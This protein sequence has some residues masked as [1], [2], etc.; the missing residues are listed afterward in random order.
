MKCFVVVDA[1]S[2]EVISASLETGR[3]EQHEPGL[4]RP[5][6]RVGEPGP[7]ARPVAAD[8]QRVLE[9]DVDETLLTG[10]VDDSMSRLRESVRRHLPRSG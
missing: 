6:D 1:A 3:A 2:G 10:L 4:E 8:G 7:Q 9:I 5:V